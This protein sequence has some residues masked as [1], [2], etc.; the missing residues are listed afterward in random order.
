MEILIAEDD[1]TSR[2]VLEST[3]RKRGYEVI[4]VSDGESA[5]F[6]LSR[7]IPPRIALLDWEMPGLTG[8]EICRRVRQRADNVDQY[9]FLVIL[10]GRGGLE[11]TIEG[12]EA[13]ADDYVKKPFNVEEL[14]LR[15]RAGQRIIELQ[16]Q[17]VATKQQL[18]LQA[19]RDSLTGMLN[20]RVVMARIHEEL[21]R[22]E[23]QSGVLGIGMID[24]D[25][26][27][28]VNDTHGHQAG[29]SVLIEGRGART[30][31]PKRIRRLRA[32]RWRGVLA[33]S[34][35]GPA[36]PGALRARARSNRR[37]SRGCRWLPDQCHRQRGS[38][39][40]RR[41]R[42]HGARDSPGRRRALSR[43][44]RRTKSS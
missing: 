38:G 44:G 9:I 3:L 43:Q 17:L 35:H 26:F 6:E 41:R 8:P 24:L 42:C 32:L 21:Q 30:W 36:Q 10:T 15:I 16:D 1:A 14:E 40:G 22:A 2:L 18:R 5:L 7:D 4:A 20:R 39:L 13:G 11:E 29:D 34:S 33:G 37:T 27:K 25:H 19:E 28:Q 12:L 31:M 23:R